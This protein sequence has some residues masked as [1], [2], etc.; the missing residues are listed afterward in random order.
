MY[1]RKGT[2]RQ[3]RTSFFSLS[4]SVGRTVVGC[5]AKGL[6][7]GLGLLQVQT[8][9][10]YRPFGGTSTRQCECGEWQDAHRCFLAHSLSLSLCVSIEGLCL[11]ALPACL[12]VNQQACW[13]GTAGPPLDH[14]HRRHQPCCHAGLCFLGWYPPWSLPRAVRRLRLRVREHPCLHA[15]EASWLSGSA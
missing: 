15:E 10:S 9:P 4:L 2:G 12:F 8:A 7:A 3:R 13:M 14:Y 1:V 5:K 11:S 6:A